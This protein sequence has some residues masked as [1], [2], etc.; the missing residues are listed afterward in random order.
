MRMNKA[1]AE[2]VVKRVTHVHRTLIDDKRIKWK[3]YQRLCCLEQDFTFHS[4]RGDM[5]VFLA[6]VPRRLVIQYER[7]F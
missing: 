3:T 4:I 1:L 5:V 6:Q 2:V 7:A